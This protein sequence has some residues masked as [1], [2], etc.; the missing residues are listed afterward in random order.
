VKTGDIKRGTKMAFF[1]EVNQRADGPAY[2]AEF[3]HGESENLF[4]VNSLSLYNSFD[5]LVHG[6]QFV[7][8]FEVGPMIYTFGARLNEKTRTPYL[9]AVEQVGAIKAFNRR[10][11]ERDELLFKV[12]I[13]DLPPENMKAGSF[14]SLA[15]HS[16]LSD[17]T[18][19]IS[20]GGMCVF[21]DYLLKSKYD[22]Y[23]LV[24]LVITAKDNFILPAKLVRRTDLKRTGWGRYEYGFQFLYDSFSDVERRITE[25]IMR[26]KLG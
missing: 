20:T 2:E 18:Y 15:V 23:Y 22:P 9:V 25:A 4:V 10:K 19:D 7:V 26:R 14:E 21:S 3:R 17:T 12:D 24:K 13:Y 1:K 16:I 8:A 6:I 11:R 5:L